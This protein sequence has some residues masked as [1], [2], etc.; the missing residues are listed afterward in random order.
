MCYDGPQLTAETAM[1]SGRK[2]IALRLDDETY[3]EVAGIAEQELRP[4]ANMVEV[5]LRTGLLKYRDEHSGLGAA[6]TP[7]ARLGVPLRTVRR[8]RRKGASRC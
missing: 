3:D 5:L 2:V 7:A 1:P 8:P 4:V 6:N